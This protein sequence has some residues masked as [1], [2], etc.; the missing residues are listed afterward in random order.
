[1]NIEELIF[2][3]YGE[4]KELE[5][6]INSLQDLDYDKL[7]EYTDSLYKLKRKLQNLENQSYLERKADI[8][9]ADIDLYLKN[10][11]DCKEQQPDKY[12]YIITLHGT[13]TKIGVIDVRFNLLESEK[14][15][16]NIGAYI[17]EDYRGN[18]YS[19]KAF[20]L[21]KDVM[22]EHNLRKPI[23]TVLTTNT[24]SI[25]SLAAIGAKRVELVDNETEPY[26]IYDY[27]LEHESI[28]K[29]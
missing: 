7:H 4:I 12:S 15:F 1:M 20:L 25:K 2:Q 22:L 24:S 17:A 23:F 27:D 6:K 8:E 26:Y 10:L 29:K 21:L 28:N 16:G 11:H 9:S 3:I 5:N 18:R 13:K 14:S 19:K